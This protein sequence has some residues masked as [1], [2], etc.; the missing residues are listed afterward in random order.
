M[1]KAQKSR[2]EPEEIKDATGFDDAFEDMELPEGGQEITGDIVGY[3]DWEKSAIRCIPR[4][5]KMFD[6]Q[7]EPH[8]VS[9][10]ILA[11]LTRPCQTYIKADEDNEDDGDEEGRVY[12]KTGVGQ[13]VGVWYKP[14]MRAIVMKGG[15]DCYIKQE[16]EKKTGKPNPMKKFKVVAGPGGFKLP[17]IEDT[18]EESEDVLTAFHDRSKGKNRPKAAKRELPEPEEDDDDTLLE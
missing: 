11:E 12:T 6:G 9:I 16:G 14:G 10:L 3:W 15:V 7:I 5:V 17:I 1:A 8:K 18:R 4:S 2:P 13:M